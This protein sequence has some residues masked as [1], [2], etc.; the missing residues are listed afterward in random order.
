MDDIDRDLQHRHL[1]S[2]RVAIRDVELEEPDVL[3]LVAPRLILNPKDISAGA[4]VAHEE[5]E[6]GRRRLVRATART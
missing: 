2:D 5:I 4:A 3:R 6:R 1:I